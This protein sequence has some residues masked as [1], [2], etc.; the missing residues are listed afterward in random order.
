MASHDNYDK[1]ILKALQDIDKSLRSIADSLG[2]ATT[3]AC[4][5]SEFIKHPDDGCMKG[6]KKDD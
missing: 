5:Y 3:A 2:K 6:R 1:N 4:L